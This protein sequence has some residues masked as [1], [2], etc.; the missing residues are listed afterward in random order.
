MPEACPASRR[1]Q[2]KLHHNCVHA[3]KKAFMPEACPA[4]RRGQCELH[5]NQNVRESE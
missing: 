5:H 2:C 3:I 1:G 4:S